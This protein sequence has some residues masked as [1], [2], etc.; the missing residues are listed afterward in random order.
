M[1]R[2]FSREIR[3]TCCCALAQRRQG[4]VDRDVAT[5]DDDD[6]RPDPDRFAA[7]HVPQEIDAPEHEGLMDTFDRDQ[8]GPLRAEA[9]EHGVV[10]LSKRLE[11][12]DLGAGMDRD[13]S[14]R[15]WS[16]SW[17]SRSGGRR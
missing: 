15:I 11:A 10:V 7:A 9:K 4:D 8:A 3:S 5:A 2:R 1:S 16:S 13:P 14:A 12:A 6:P 17:S